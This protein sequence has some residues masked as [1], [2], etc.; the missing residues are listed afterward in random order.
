M[1][2]GNVARL[3]TRDFSVKVHVTG[4]N[5]QNERHS[6][7]YYE[8]RTKENQSHHNKSGPKLLKSSF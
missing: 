2:L 1:G 7:S 6:S 4:P 8:R 5:K 3:K